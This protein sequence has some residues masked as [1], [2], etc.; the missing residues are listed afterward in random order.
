MYKLERRTASSAQRMFSHSSGVTAENEVIYREK[1]VI[2]LM[3]KWLTSFTLYANIKLPS[4]T[5]EG[6]EVTSG[7]SKGWVSSL[8][9]TEGATQV[10]QLYRR[11]AL[12][13][14]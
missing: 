8:K 7:I 14:C 6:A 11:T 3:Q 5:I 4:V 9:I 1:I 10:I 13:C 12:P 2:C